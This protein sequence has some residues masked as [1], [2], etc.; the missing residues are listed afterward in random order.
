MRSAMLGSQGRLLLKELFVCW[1]D[2]VERVRAGVVDFVAPI[3]GLL[4][5]P[6]ATVTPL[7]ACASPSREV[8]VPASPAAVCQRQNSSGSMRFHSPRASS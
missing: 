1:W 3:M 8:E 7:T 2:M 4:S 6:A 5:R